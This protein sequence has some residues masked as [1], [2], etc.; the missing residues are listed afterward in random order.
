MVEYR[1]TTD[2]YFSSE[3]FH[4]SREAADHVNQQGHRQRLMKTAGMVCQVL[5]DNPIIE[6]VIDYGAGNG[7]LLRLISEWPGVELFGYD[8]CEANVRQAESFGTPVT[9]RN[10]IEQPGSTDLAIMC[11]VLEHMVDPHGFL[12]SLDTD[13]IV[14]SVPIGETPEH[15]Y[16]YHLWGWDDEGF[17]AAITGAGYDIERHVLIESTQ[18]VTAR[19]LEHA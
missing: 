12:R 10:F 4:R 19:K 16:E 17:A 6:T 15:H 3:E 8:F 13:W 14:A 9:F 5:M 7:G 2:D 18:I 11:E 1:F